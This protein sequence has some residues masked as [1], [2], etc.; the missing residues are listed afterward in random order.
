VQAI[1]NRPAGVWRG[2]LVTSGD[3]VRFT[4]DTR[5]NGAL[6]LGRRWLTLS[7]V[8]VD[9]SS[10][11]FTYD[12][13]ADAP[14]TGVDIAILRRARSL[15]ADESGWNRAD[16]TDMDAAPI[17]G[18]SC[19]P[20]SKQ[21]L[22]C[23]V[24]LA[25]IDVAGDYAHFRPAIAAIREALAVVTA[26]AYRHPL[27]DFNNDPVTRLEQIHATFDLAVQLVEEQ[28]SAR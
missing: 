28:R 10:I 25:S 12:Q 21:S 27:I 26:K 11:R 2:L 17:R 20:A 7:D 15:L 14:A 23:A 18:F 5:P 9:S 4:V 1:A 24:Y 13:S 8:K 3:S 22:F 6:Q 16:T 19:A